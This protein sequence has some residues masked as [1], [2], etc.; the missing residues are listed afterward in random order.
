MFSPEE[1]T[2]VKP[3]TGAFQLGCFIATTF[4]FMGVVYQFYPDKA[5]TPREFEGGLE[6]ELGGPT[7]IRVCKAIFT[8]LFRELTRYQ[9]RA[10]GDA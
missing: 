5:S 4:A 9:A 1:Y 8:V 6:R 7:A 10:A 2:H 3:A